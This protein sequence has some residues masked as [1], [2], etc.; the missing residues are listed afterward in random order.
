MLNVLVI[1]SE[2]FF[3]AETHATVFFIFRGTPVYENIYRS[4]KG[5]AGSLFPPHRGSVTTRNKLQINVTWN[6]N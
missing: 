5:I 6:T 2:F 1:V 3:E 4:E